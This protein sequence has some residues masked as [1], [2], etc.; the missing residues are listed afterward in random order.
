MA[1]PKLIGV[2]V[3][4]ASDQRVGK[5]EDML[6]DHDGKVEIVVIGVGGF[7]GI[8]AKDVA[9]PFKA[10]SWH[11]EP[12]LVPSTSPPPS[13]SIGT[14]GQASTVSYRTIDPARTEAHQGYP[15]KAHINLTREQLKAAP[16]F[17]YA[18]SPLADAD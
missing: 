17:E 10:L 8:G 15:D 16:D 4:D 11:T 2:G 14:T 6:V 5:I 7:L 18:Q 13:G 1:R 12:R 3:Y 9:V